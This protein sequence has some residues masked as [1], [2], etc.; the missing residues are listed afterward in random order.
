MSQDVYSLMQQRLPEEALALVRRAGALAAARGL[1]ICLV[2]GVVRDILLGRSSSD[3]DLV[4]EGDAIGLAEALAG[5][6]GGKLVVHRRFGTAK[7]RCGMQAI[8]LA[9]ARAETYARPGALPT[10]RA[11]SLREDLA[12]RDF[13]INAMALRLAPDGPGDLVDPFGGRRDLEGRTIR[14][15]HDR[16]FTD[17]ATRMLRAVRYEQRFGFRL[18][19]ATEKL[20]RRDVRRLGTISGDRIRHELDLILKEELPEKALLRA[21]QLGLL[22]RV[23][24]ALRAGPWLAPMFERARDVAPTVPPALYYALMTSR[25]DPAECADFILS[26][27]T[28]AAVS[29]AILD[30]ALLRE[31]LTQLEGPGLPPSAI[32]ALLDEYR[33]ISVL[34][35]AIAEK[36][37]SRQGLLLRYLTE[38]RQ[39][40]PVL[41]GDD[42]RRMGVPPGP[43]IGGGLEEL[44]RARLDGIIEG[45]EG[46]EALVREWL[47]RGR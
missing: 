15:L 2:G 29:R 7:V 13:T 14:I 18:E 35:C 43:L 25:L 28:P 20:L 8:D 17:D 42:L 12:R 16:S 3:L 46:E 24:P 32:C 11:G 21:G 6:T 34:A 4:V 45:R 31:R 1:E 19:E 30:S 41:D 33:P 40:R 23:H 27:K 26:L 5:Q 36:R 22:A 44:R 47:S 39:V 9:M 10:V 38:W 37:K